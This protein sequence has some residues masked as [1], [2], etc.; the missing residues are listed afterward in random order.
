MHIIGQLGIGGCE[1]QL[2]DLCRRMDSSR[3][4]LTVCWYTRF[5][6][7]LSSEFA[8]AGVRLIFIDKFQMPPWRFFGQLMQAIRQTKPDIVHTWLYSANAWGRWAALASRVPC[9]VGSE[10]TEIRGSSRL[11]RISERLLAKRSKVLVNS[12]AVARS[13]EKHYG[14]PFDRIQVVYNAVSLPPCDSEM[15]RLSVRKELGIPA[16]QKLVVMVGRLDPDKNWPMF[17]RVADRVRRIRLDVYFVAIGSG[18]LHEELQRMVQSSSGLGAYLRFAGEK[19]DVSRWLAA[20]DLFCFTSDLEGFPNAV[21]EAMLSGLTVL[22]TEFDSATEVLTNPAVGCLVP[23]ND[24]QAMA[25]QVIELLDNPARRQTIGEAARA[26]VENR[27]DWNTL[28]QTMEQFYEAN[29][30]TARSNV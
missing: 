17:V 3:Y 29:L 12:G 14:V 8:A 9:I 25:Q 24:D 22:C 18:P 19:R 10:R 26:M 4:E 27:H 23:K 30:L 13:M 7:E 16:E 15:A 11:Y 1:K 20:A 6:G 21:L 28:V 5:P 2:L